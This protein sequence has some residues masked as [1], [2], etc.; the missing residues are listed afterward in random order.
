M[1]RKDI[2]TGLIVILIITVL[3]GYLLAQVYKITKIRIDEQKQSEEQRLYKEIFPEGEEFSEEKEYVAVYD[4]DDRPLGRI[5][6]IVEAGY[7]GPIVIKAGFDIDSKIKDVR[8]LEETE[9]PGLGV[10][11]KE[12]TFLDQFTGKSGNMLYLKKYNSEGTID[13][14]TGAT[15][16][17]K[18]VSDGIIKAQERIERESGLNNSI[19]ATTEGVEK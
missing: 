18:A 6:H 4:G 12:K 16:S 3:S 13:A 11:I 17:S 8:I 1:K 9:T 10:K 5:Y 7:G 15:I 14:I 19:E 2:V